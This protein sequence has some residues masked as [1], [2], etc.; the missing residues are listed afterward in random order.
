M[1]DYWPVSDSCARAWRKHEGSVAREL[2][3]STWSLGA[4]SDRVLD[5]GHCLFERSQTC[6]HAQARSV[7]AHTDAPGAALI[8]QREAYAAGPQCLERRLRVVH[9][10]EDIACERWRL[11]DEPPSCR[12]GVALL[13]AEI[14]LSSAAA[15]IRKVIVPAFRVKSVEEKAVSLP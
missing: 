5:E 7:V 2:V 9:L 10:A 15:R 13:R 14:R 8:P 11:G 3:G 6:F 4:A 1:P 12:P